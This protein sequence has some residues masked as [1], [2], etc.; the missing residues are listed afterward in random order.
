MS[1]QDQQPNLTKKSSSATRRN[2][3]RGMLW[4]KPKGAIQRI[5]SSKTDAPQPAN[6]T[7]TVL[8]QTSQGPPASPVQQWSIAISTQPGVKNGFE[9]LQTAIDEYNAEA[10]QQQRELIDHQNVK[11]EE[12]RKIAEEIQS[13]SDKR[14]SEKKLRSMVNNGLRKFCETSLYYSSIM[15]TLIQHNPEWIILAWGAVKFMLM[16]PI[17]YQRVKENIAMHLGSL[18]E[19]FAVVHIFTQFFPSANIIDAAAAM[20]TSFAEFLEVS[21]RWLSDNLFKR[22]IKSTFRPFDTSLKPI[23]EKINHSYTILREHVEAQKLIRDY[24]LNQQHHE[25]LISLKTSS[26]TTDKKLTRVLQI[27][28]GLILEQQRPEDP[29]SAEKH[30][31]P[32]RVVKQK[33][34][35]LQLPALSQ[36]LFASSLEPMDH[37][38][39]LMQARQALSPIMQTY[40]GTN[41]L[42]RDDFRKWISNASSGLLWVDGYE[43]PGR[44]SWL[45]DLALRVT[46]AAFMS[47]YEALYTFNSLRLRETEAFTPLSLIQRLSNHLLR[48]YPEIYEL[49][50]AELLCPEI[51]LAAETD[52]GLSWKIFVECLTTMRPVAIYIILESI[53]G[54]HLTPNNRDQF[55]PVLQRFSELATP[56]AIKNKIVKIMITSTKP[57]AGFNY[58]FGEPD[59]KSLQDADSTH[60]LVRVSPA[61]ARSRKQRSVPG[62]KRRVRIP[63]NSHAMA[64]LT[65]HCEKILT[66]DDFVPEP[67][68]M[69]VDEFIQ[70]MDSDEDFDIYEETS[71]PFNMSV[72]KMSHSVGQVE[73]SDRNNADFSINCSAMSSES[74]L[75]I[76]GD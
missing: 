15:D 19:K 2:L 31:L 51:F 50:D 1:N 58:I 46:Q 11:L 10:S 62:V 55:Q 67:E 28:E 69:E 8:G 74:S 42:Q 23:L 37:D 54:M 49:G 71:S 4:S 53:D 63:S 27:L 44:P 39:D 57:D 43:K 20:Y 26:D 64:G 70:E 61:A 72:A 59:S 60:V 47:G 34:R 35:V 3:Y 7:T 75:D 16:I 36:K 45:G 73:V 30:R 5:K 38:L 22:I 24:Q 65:F 6:P 12:V 18:G 17:E 25:D 33:P 21:V 41:I 52:V 76:F 14:N 13:N 68:H 66:D 29:R 32:I 56:G 40:E 48:K 9:R